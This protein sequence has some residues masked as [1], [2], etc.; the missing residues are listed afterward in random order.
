MNNETKTTLY[1]A[2]AAVLLSLIAFA[3]TPKRITPESFADQGQPFFP[4]FTDPNTAAT[5]E[6]IEYD[7]A[8]ASPMPFKVTFKDG[9]WTIPS[10]YDYAADGKDRLAKTAAGVI[11]VKK[12]DLRSTNSADQEACGVIDPSEATT[13]IRGR[14]TRVTLRAQGDQTLAD[15]I[16]GKPVEGREG[17][18]FV[19]IPGTSRIY[20]CRMNIELSTKFEDWIET[21]LLNVTKSKI[22][23][24]TLRDYSINERTNSVDQRENVTLA[25]SGGKWEMKGAKSA[26]P[27]S[28]KVDSLLK[29]LD[30]LRIVGV[31]TKPT[32]LTANL[33]G[34]KAAISQ[35]DI[36]SLQS[37][38]Y[39][40]SRDGQLLSNEGELIVKTSEGVA[41]TLRFGEVVYGT[42]TTVS[43]GSDGADGKQGQGENRYLFVTA[44]FDSKNLTPP[45][46]PS[47][48]LFLN[49]PDSLLTDEDRANKNLQASYDEWQR[50]VDN[51]KKIAAD[52]NIRFAKW[53][54]VISAK[55]FEA[56]HLSRKDLASK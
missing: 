29:T 22:N 10:H 42:G 47:N 2:G 20:T 9:R 52:L 30:D 26:K 51:G 3:M 45:K 4:D 1:F 34:D 33:T 21:D 44:D 17:F 53:Y 49:K 54:Y 14:G 5:L 56:L 46:K 41:Y 48:Q 39:Y 32:G 8:T 11:D 24:V 12:D 15:F 6:V 38:G 36:M 43:A 40:L 16:I 23:E 55:A 18:R 19:R 27:D 28:V 13:A 31:R 25:L 50:N 7:T 35:Q 37:R